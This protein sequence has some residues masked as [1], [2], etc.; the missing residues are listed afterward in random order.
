MCTDTNNDK[1][2]TN[3]TPPPRYEPVTQ[4]DASFA[5]TKLSVLH[6]WI[7]MYCKFVGLELSSNQ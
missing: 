5:H 3:L 2:K 6:E 1:N 4:L 7:I